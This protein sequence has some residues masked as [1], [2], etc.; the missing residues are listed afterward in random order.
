MLWLPQLL[1]F[2][3]VRNSFPD[4]II[5]IVVSCAKTIITFVWL[6]HKKKKGFCVKIGVI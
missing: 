5:I 1:V 4:I 6:E 3:V 2:R